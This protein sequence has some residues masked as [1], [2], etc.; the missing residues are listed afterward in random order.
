MALPPRRLGPLLPGLRRQ[1]GRLG[2]RRPA[3]LRGG[4]VADR[5]PLVEEEALEGL[6]EVV[7]QVPAVRHLR[8]LGRAA[9]RPVGVE[10]ATVTADDLD[11]GVFHEPRGDGV[12]GAVGE[13]VDDPVP[14]QIDQHRAEAAPAPPGPV[15]DPED[16]RG[17]YRRQRRGPD[18]VQECIRAGVESQ[19]AEQPRP[20]L[21]AEGESDRL[22]DPRQAAGAAGIRR[23]DGG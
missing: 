13:E 8:G 11:P 15:I 1:R 4:G 19:R 20:A 3:H 5:A 9:R 22:H 10:T 16:A 6:A 17:R 18:S 7:Q 2:H 21:T 23:D 12:C 14:L